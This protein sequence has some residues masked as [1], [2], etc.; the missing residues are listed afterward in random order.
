LLPTFPL[1]SSPSPPM[2][3]HARLLCFFFFFWICGTFKVTKRYLPLR[4]PGV[5]F[6]P[7]ASPKTLLACV[8]DHLLSMWFIFHRKGR[9]FFHAARVRPLLPLP[10]N[11][12]HPFSFQSHLLFFEWSCLPSA[13]ILL[14]AAAGV[15]SSYRNANSNLSLAAPPPFLGVASAL[16]FAAKYSVCWTQR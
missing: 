2:T 3:V 9:G 5:L 8:K 11:F 4:V 6:W 14:S 13:R 1:P 7:I 12:R 16:F 15:S 10:P